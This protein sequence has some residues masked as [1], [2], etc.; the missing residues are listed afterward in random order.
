M[1]LWKE[2]RET[3]HYDEIAESLVPQVGNDPFW[4]Q[5]SRTLLS[6]ILKNV[7]EEE[8][9][10]VLKMSNI[11]ELSNLHKC[12]SKTKAAAL[13]D[14]QS[15][16]TATSIRMNLA[17]NIAC[18]E[19]LKGFYDDP[20]SIRDWVQ[21]RCFPGQASED[22][23]NRDL[24]AER[25]RSRIESGTPLRGGW[26][27]LSMNPSQRATLRP[28]LSCW[29]SIAIKSLMEAK[30]DSNRRVF[31]MID[32]LPSLHKLTD[33]SLCLSEGRKYGACLFLGIQNIPQLEKTYGRQITESLVDLCSTKIIFRNAS[34]T[35]AEKLS[36]LIGTQE[37][38]EV[39][40]GISYGA[41]DM[42]DG[43]SL[44]MTTKEKPVIPPH[45]LLNLPDLE[46]YI[47]LPQGYPI[48]KTKWGLAR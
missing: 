34:F 37:R 46:S 3:Y 29:L 4:A 45:D 18:L 12:L 40:E 26:L 5:S 42:R 11:M 36:R 6:E 47:H 14:P 33:L 15:E 9:Q 2:C 27:F 24:E 19:H 31:F 7:E 48:T 10:E 20:V 38:Q 32:E 23:Q 41:N 21:G 13:I 30:P 39:Q 17:S 35:M 28:L 44:N 8:V 16:K 43:V 25:E 22:A 1:D